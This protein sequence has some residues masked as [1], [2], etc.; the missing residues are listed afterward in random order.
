MFLRIAG[1]WY[2]YGAEKNLVV[3]YNTYK[4]NVRTPLKLNVFTRTSRHNIVRMPTF[5]FLS[6]RFLLS[7][8]NLPIPCKFSLRRCSQCSCPSSTSTIVDFR[9]TFA[10]WGCSLNPRLQTPHE[11]FSI[12]LKS[13]KVA[14]QICVGQKIVKLFFTRACVLL[15][16][17]AAYHTAG[18][19]SAILQQS[20]LSRLYHCAYHIEVHVSISLRHSSKLIR[21]LTS[22]LLEILPTANAI[23]RTGF[24]PET[25]TRGTIDHNQ[26]SYFLFSSGFWL[27]LFSPV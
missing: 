18:K 7:L 24:W 15:A 8:R 22:L 13:N 27:S 1:W 9:D 25:F 14:R 21:C 4:I 6:W 2:L 3:T 5:S 26:Q 16:W 11:S 23:N 19:G 20:S 17:C 10:L 12:Q